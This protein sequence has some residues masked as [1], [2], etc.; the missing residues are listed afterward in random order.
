MSKKYLS[1]SIFTLVF[2]AFLFVFLASARQSK[3]YAASA[4]VAPQN[5]LINQQNFKVNVFVESLETEPKVASTELTINHS[6]N[7]KVLTIEKGEFTNYT[8]TN[9]D[10]A[11]N[12]IKIAANNA[13][14]TSG[15]VRLAT[16]T[17]SVKESTGEATVNIAT[18]STIVGAGSEQILTESIQGKYILDVQL[19]AATPTPTGGVSTQPS[20]PETGGSDMM[21]YIFASVVLVAS[22]IYLTQRKQ[23]A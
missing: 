10:P 13:T 9:F 12:Q 21:V 22:G 7:I 3:I 16:I 1:K 18:T 14:P 4:Y 23:R 15:K 20:V 6:A 11:T 8:Q 2:F 19:A 5:G 17:F